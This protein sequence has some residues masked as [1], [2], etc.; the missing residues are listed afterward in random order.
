MQTHTGT[1]H[2]WLNLKPEFSLKSSAKYKLEPAKDSAACSRGQT[3]IFRCAPYS[4]G[5]A[6]GSARLLQAQL[7]LGGGGQK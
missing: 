6:L 3:Q 2:F 4:A 5:I 1:Q 7:K